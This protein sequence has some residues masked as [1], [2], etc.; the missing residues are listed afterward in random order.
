VYN[1]LH[2]RRQDLLTPFLG[3]RAYKGRFSTGKTHFVLPLLTGFYRWT[4]SQQRLFAD[5]LTQVTQDAQRDVYGLFQAIHQLAA[6]PAV[7]PTRLVGLADAR[8]EN[9]AVR[10]TALRALARLDGGQGVPVLLEALDDVRARIAIYALRSTLLEM[11][12]ARALTLLQAVPT[13]K[14]T[15]A[16]EVI[17][18]LGDLDTPAVYPLLLEMDARPLHRDVRVAQLRA[19][20]PHLERPETWPILYRAAADPDPAVA[21]GVVWLPTDR[22]SPAAQQHVL[23][24]LAA[25]L[26][27]PDALLR[28]QVLSRFVTLPLADP[29]R[30]LLPP[31]L[32]RLHSPL[33][34]EYKAAARALFATYA[35]QHA[36]AIAETV[37]Q[38][39]PERRV[40]QALL[41]AL[42]TALAANRSGLQPV[43]QGILAALRPDPLT[44]R[45]QARLAVAGL[46][47][48]ELAPYL[49][50]LAATD[51]LD[52]EVLMATAQALEASGQRSGPQSEANS[53]AAFE[54]TLA[55][56][57]DARLR[58]LA[59]AA[60]QAQA[61]QPAGWTAALRTRLDQYRA[62]PAPLVAAA[63]QF[64][65]P[66][67]ASEEI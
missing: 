26:G 2:R 3:Q 39:R 11:P 32:A 62:D 30:V 66:P 43:V 48:P 56:N 35:Q 47:W 12:A 51:A 53:V 57:P 49:T 16:K 15:V 63:A 14:V 59:Q 24:L 34:D 7:L 9:L 1:Y 10:D 67:P 33:P 5:T 40:L 29:G 60:L 42:H 58:R 25:L 64:V 36:A 20:W 13:Q 19:I 50:E 55:A 6:L 65:F 38:V 27:H 54:Y 61:T 21:A 31:L 4:P 46:P 45:L 18:L 41:Q 28:V 52:A 22:L 17:R 23:A 37:A 44:V 8:M